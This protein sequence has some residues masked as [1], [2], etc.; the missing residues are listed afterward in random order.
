MAINEG[1]LASTVQAGAPKQVL[2]TIKDDDVSQVSFASVSGSVDEGAGTHNVTVNVDPVS[3]ADFTL[4]YGLGGTAV[5]GTDYSISGSGTVSVS[6]GVSSVDIPIMLTDD[7]VDEMNETVILTLTSGVGYDIGSTGVHTLTITDNDVSEAI[8]AS[9]SGTVSEGG[10]THDVTVNIDPAPVVGFTLNYNLGGTATKG[11]DYSI[12]NSGTVTVGAGAVSVNIPVV[13]TD[14]SEEEN[15][16]TV[17]LTLSNSTE[18]IVGSTNEYTLTI[19]DNDTPALPMAAFASISANVDEDVGTQNVTVSLSRAAPAGGL[20]LNYDLDGTATRGTDYSIS[21]AGTVSA[22]A[23]ILSVD[24]PVVITDD[25][26]KENEE[27][28]ILTLKSGTGYDVGSNNVYT[29]TIRDDDA[30]PEVAFATASASVDEGI[31][32]RNVT[33]NISPAPAADFTLSYGLGGTAV[34]GTDYSITG[35]GSIL[36]AAGVVS[37]NIPVMITDDTEDEKDETIILTISNST[38]YTVGTASVHTLTITDNDTPE[39]AFASVSGSVDEGAGTHNVTI[40]IDPVS[41]ADFTLNYGLGGTADEGTDYSISGSGT[42]SVGAGVSSVEISIVVTDDSADEM[43]ETVILRLTSGVGY[44]IGSTGMH[45]LTITDNDVSQVA[46]ASLSGTVSE[47]AGTHNVTVNVDPVSAADFTLNYGLGGTAVEGTDYSISGSGTVSV[48]AGVSSVDIPIMLTDDSVDEMN[49]TVILTLTSGV[50]YDIGSTG[51]HTLTITDNDT[52]ALPAAAF[53]S[54]SANVDEDVGTQNVAVSLSRA[55]PAGGLT[56]SYDL[57]GTAT[58]G[59]DYSISG[60]GTVSAAAGVLSVDIPVVITDDIVKENEETVILTLKSGTGYDVGSNNVYTLTIRDDDATP[61]VAFATASAS[62]DEGIGTRN[63]TINISPAPAADFTLS[64]GLGGTAVKG[65]DYSITGSGSILV[66][67]GVVSVNIPVMI[68]D[69]TEDE[70]DETIILTISNSTEYTVG[71]ASVHTLTITD[72]DTPEAAFASVSGSVDE[73]AGTHNVTINIDPVSAAD[74]TL[75]YGLGGTADEGTDYSI[76]GSGTVSVGAGVSSVEIPIVLTDDRYDENDETVILTLTGSTKYTLGSTNE[77]TLTIED[78]DESGI[79]APAFVSVEEG[80]TN[81]F[82]VALTSEPSDEVTVRITGHAGKGL[83][84]DVTTLTFSVS[85]WE[86]VQTVTLTAIEDDDAWNDTVTLTLSSTGRG[87]NATHE[88]AVTITDN[89]EAKILAPQSVA[90]VEGSTS[91]VDIVLSAQPS[92]NVTVVITG[93]AD[94]DLTLDVTALS[95]TDSNWKDPQTVTLTAAEDDQDVRHDALTLTLSA[96]GGDYNAVHEIAVTI[97]DNDVASISAVESMAVDEG[98]T[99]TLEVVLSAQPSGNVTVTVTGY[100]GSDLADIPPDPNPLTFT[101][102]NYNSAQKV[103]L[104]AIEDDDALNDTVTLTLS[105][106]GGDYNA[107]HEIAVTITDNDVA[108]ISAVESVAVDEGSTNTLDVALSAQPSGN[109]TVTITGHAGTDLTLD[110][111]VLT[112]GDSNWEDTQTVT[113]T[114]DDDNDILDD[115]VP[116]MLSAA[117][118]GYDAAHEVAVTITDDDVAVRLSADPSS[119][120]EGSATAV[121]ATLSGTLPN[122]VRIGLNNVDGTTEP[123][124]YVLL[125]S[126]TISAG[127]LTGS[128]NLLTNDDDISEVNEVFTV[129]LGTLPANVV[130]GIPSSVEITILDDGDL[131]PPVEVTLSVDPKEVEEG[132]PVTVTLELGKELTV[133]VVVPLMYPSGATAEPGDYIALGSVVIPRG[134]TKGTGQ[135]VTVQDTDV[136]DETFTVALGDLPPELVAG[137]TSS[138]LVT[139]RDVFPP[140]EVSVRLLVSQSLV[141]EGNTATVTVE[142]SEERVT[143]VTVPLILSGTAAAQDYRAPIPRQVEFKAG[144]TS[145]TYVISIL[146]DDISEEDETITVAFG[147]LP[148]GVVPGD[149]S[150][151]ELRIIDDDEAGIATLQ[152]VSVVEEGAESFDLSLTSKPTDV[153]TVTMTWPLNTDIRLTPFVHIFTPDNW[154]QEQEATLNASDDPDV[155]DDQ[156]LVTLTATGGGYTG[157]SETVNVTI[158]DNDAAGINAPASVTVSEG[159]SETFDVRLVAAP[160][161]A[162]TVTVPGTLGDLTATPTRLTFTAENWE[163]SQSITLMAGEDDDFLFDTEI[164]TLTANGGGYDGV[165]RDMSVTIMDDDEAGIEAPAVITIEEGGIGTL[166]VRLRAA[167][168]GPVTVIFTGYA[169]SD[170][171]LSAA[172]LTFTAVTWNIPQFVTLTAAEDNDFAD[173]PVELVLT[174][175]GGG[176][177]DTHTTQVT[178]TDNDEREFPLAITIYDE[179]ES[180]DAG[181][182]QLAI[183]LSRPVDEVV[184]VQYATSNIEAVAGADYTASRGVVIFDPGATRGVIEIKIMDDDIFEESERFTVTLSNPTNAIIARGTG[185]GTILDNDGSAKL[186]VDDALVQEEEG[187]VVFRVLLSHPQRQM[188]TA[189]YRTQDGSAKAGEDYETSSGVVTIAPGTMEALIAVSILKD[190]LDWQE[191]TFTVHLESAKHAEIEKAVGVATIQEST[192]VSEG[193]LE[194]YASRFVRTASVEVVDALGDRFR[195]AADGAMCTAAERAEMAQLWYSASSWDPSLGELLAGCRLSQSMPVS[196]GSFGMWGQGAFRQFNGRGDEAL[197][198]RGEVTTGMLGADYRW[199]GGWLAGVLLAHSQGDG[200]FEVKEESG[201]MNSALT[202]IYP[203]VSYTRAGWDVWVSAGAGRGNAEVSELKGDLISRFGAM[204]MRGTLASGGAVGLSYHGDILVTDAEIADHNITAEVYRVRAGIEVTTQI[205]G[206]IRPYVEVNV[207]QDGGSAET[208]TGLELGGG[209]RFSNPAWRLR[210]EVQTQGLIL[211]TA[212]GFTEWGISGSLQMGSSSEGL[213]MRLRP[214]WGRGHGMS[215]YNQQTILDAAPTG[216]NAHRTELELGYGIPWKGGSARSIMGVTQRSRGMMYRLGG[217]LRPWERLSFSVF[218][219]AHG[220][221]AALGNIGVNL[222]GRLQY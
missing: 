216:A 137:R 61:E 198:L 13:L 177:D 62:V 53:A 118:G 108:S 185:T 10:G 149:P 194:A 215:M 99:N 121:T 124:D 68:T 129:A 90:V 158:I 192:T 98:D 21:G 110:V 79:Q 26:V 65:T 47:G 154:D 56:L 81:T 15:P 196:G 51:V 116:L 130:P 147:T 131:P 173:D 178:I 125:K 204:G 52:P 175:S 168:S 179:R 69:D 119:V 87:Y 146:Q 57:D 45:T 46:F 191:E 91:T 207:R 197:T 148:S 48:S 70:K 9:S 19:T 153:V 42:V 214:S 195:A 170:L 50:G 151:I 8:F 212:D 128:G 103:T 3:A 210:G 203:Y 161:A 142:L 78:N 7:S 6:A 92:G 95:F 89:D 71:T 31:G 144:A 59:T 182:L 77:H 180:E 24:I 193:V 157:I 120:V 39:A 206:E 74:F 165:T 96:T 162:V 139:I 18:Y 16:E 115:A 111:A 184:T 187:V 140:K 172:S 181:G 72:N 218:G 176:Y 123:S 80:G 67:A 132:N 22:A 217:E 222:N 82:N 84:P 138:Q 107:G 76:S 94:T 85:N 64:Y 25:I 199:R 135:I 41:A 83:T 159:G 183:E 141:N 58:R 145:A 114:A 190:G 102:V 38:E 100:A 88:V 75:N 189:E 133:D 17:I 211:H 60:A 23:G 163:M 150:E 106:T 32:T 202:G 136:E 44:D 93:Y 219:L 104:T 152:S 143:D 97:T 134:Q 160:S 11:T 188:V 167:P 4:N 66:A 221:E 122:E 166:P 200:S 27:T 86:N 34:K 174:A 213:M 63:V 220:H 1:S 33:I 186:R 101:P 55:A 5:E 169:G 112:F 14:D 171:A 49:E 73:G 155:M 54:I 28:V 43:N 164:L 20:T 105:A 127:A 208:G 205:T 36:V 35:S 37:V 201:E 40:N 126:I 109:V 156:V 30:T 117:G 113:L 2:I 29:L 209:V 12:T